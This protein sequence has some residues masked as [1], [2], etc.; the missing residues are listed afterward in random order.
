MDVK[1]RYE[2]I[3]NLEAKKRDLITEKDNLGDLNLRRQK[4]L[5][6]LD[7][8]KEDYIRNYE[9]QTEDLKL[10]IKEHDNVLDDKRSTMDA[11]IA[12]IDDSLNRLNTV[13]K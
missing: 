9:R 8:H 1:S 6:Q 2:V 10:L 5:T 13:S 3:A 11:L 7:R 12:S 4:E